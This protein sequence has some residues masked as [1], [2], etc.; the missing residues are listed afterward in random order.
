MKNQSSLNKAKNHASSVVVIIITKFCT[1]SMNRTGFFYCQIIVST[2]EIHS[3]R[4]PL[5]TGL[6]VATQ[7]QNVMDCL[8]I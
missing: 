2:E 4:H 3:Q 8:D 5:L 6:A 1:V 7:Y